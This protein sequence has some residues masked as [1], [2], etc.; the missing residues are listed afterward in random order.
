MNGF[1]QPGH[2]G[3]GY[4]RRV[5]GD[6]K[7]DAHVALR[8]EIIN[9]I[10]PDFFQQ[11]EQRPG[12]GQIAVMQKKLAGRGRGGAVQITAIRRGGAADDAVDF[13]TFGQQQFGKIRTVLSGDACDERFFCHSC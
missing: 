4:V 2:A 12:I 5:T 9:F 3:G 13:I 10:R 8:A 6:V 11:P 7:A 1:E